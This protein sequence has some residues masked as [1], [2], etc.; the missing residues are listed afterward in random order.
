MP[1]HAGT[2][3]LSQIAT[4]PALAAAPVPPADLPGQS[5]TVI[6]KFAEEPGPVAACP[7]PRGGRSDA[8]GPA[9]LQFGGSA[10]ASVSPCSPL[11][12]P[13]P[14]RSLRPPRAGAVIDAGRA[15]EPPT[16]GR[17]SEPRSCRRVLPGRAT[18]G[19]LWR[20]LVASGAPG[21]ASAYARGPADHLHAGRA[22]S[23]PPR[24][25]LRSGS[26]S[27]RPGGDVH[28]DGP[29]HVPLAQR[30]V[31]DPEHLRR[32]GGPGPGEPPPGEARWTDA[33]RS[34]G[35]GPAGRCAPGQLQPEPGQAP[36]AARCAWQ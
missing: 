19:H 10:A 31:V 9:L 1:R 35:A 22:A 33:R 36:S 24:G 13:G 5:L 21:A 25:R 15:G 18:G 26:R 4:F 20:D 6:T 8:A 12:D 3:Y 34:P 30:E 27:R 28:Q 11:A 17:L 32:P 7:G 2:P 23:T 16:V 14:E 29:V